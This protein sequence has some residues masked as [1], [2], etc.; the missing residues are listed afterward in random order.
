MGRAGLGVSGTW[1]ILG[2]TFDPI[3]YAHL[4]IAEQT[5]ETLGLTGVIFIPVGVPPHKPDRVISTAHHR[6]AMVEAAIDG[7]PAF[8]LSRIEV[9][10]PGPSYTTDTV[11]VIAEGLAT[12][13][14]DASAGGIDVGDIHEAASARRP[15]ASERLIVIVSVEALRMFGTWREPETI[16]SQA[17]V[18]VVPR[19][20]YPLPG[21]DDLERLA[22]LFPGREGR[23]QF[24][25][26][27]LLGI[28][29]SAI[30]TRAGAGGSVRYLVPDAVAR[31]IEEHRLYRPPTGRTRA[32]ETDGRRT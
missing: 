6:V 17:R 22:A 28:S 16:L 23:F 27:P 14:G 31:Y 1:G 5:R 8:R 2:G 29:A 18:A 24:L 32:K 25:S 4:A 15:G 7:N 10:R 3:H 30:R 19:V 26:E 11:R 13:E 9:D 20:G 21:A 12:R